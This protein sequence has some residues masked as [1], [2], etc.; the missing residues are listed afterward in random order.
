MKSIL[1]RNY[2][3]LHLLSDS[4]ANIA[5][6]DG[7]LKDQR[8]YQFNQFSMDSRIELIDSSAFNTE[9]ID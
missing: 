9:L 7:A 5:I 3:D 8:C 4:Q 1:H 2:P 6:V